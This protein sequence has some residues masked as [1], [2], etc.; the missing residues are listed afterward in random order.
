M[1]MILTS[2]T[3]GGDGFAGVRWFAKTSGVDCLH[4]E[5]VLNTLVEI[6]HAS[7]ALRSGFASLYPPW[8]VFLALLDNVSGDWRST[9]V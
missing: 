2:S 4:A 8:T 6:I 5:F 9:I 3:L 1:Q 7:L